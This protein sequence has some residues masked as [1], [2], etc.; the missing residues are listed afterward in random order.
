[1]GTL[2]S[3]VLDPSSWYSAWHEGSWA[4]CVE[5]IDEFIIGS[6]CSCSPK[7]LRGESFYGDFLPTLWRE[8]VKEGA[9]W[10]HF[11]PDCSWQLSHERA[12]EMREGCEMFMPL[13]RSAGSVKW[14]HLNLSDRSDA[15]ILPRLV[16]I[17][18]MLE[19]LG[20]FPSPDSVH[21]EWDLRKGHCDGPRVLAEAQGPGTEAMRVQDLVPTHKDRS[22]NLVLPGNEQQQVSRV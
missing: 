13:F 8:A 9:V 18:P 17:L 4:Q 14:S 19:N 15:R 7:R 6:V 16:K 12:F 1:M 21:A 11:C 10:L 22:C 2:W 20:G 5:W 3:S